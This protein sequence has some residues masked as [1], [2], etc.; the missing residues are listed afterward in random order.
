MKI[1]LTSQKA[2]F[3]I[4]VFRTYDDVIKVF[5]GFMSNMATNSRSSSSETDDLKLEITALRNQI[6]GLMAK[7]GD[8]VKQ[9]KELQEQVI[10]LLNSKSELEKLQTVKDD[11]F[12]QVI[13]DIK[14]PAALIKNLV[15]LLTSYDLQANEQQDVVQD[16]VKTSSK[17]LRL[18]QEVSRVMS[19]ESNRIPLDA[20]EC[21]LNEIVKDVVRLNK[22]A[23]D[24][25]NIKIVIDIDEN[26]PEIVMDPQKISE[27]A[28]N[29]VSNAIKFNTPG[30]MLRVRTYKKDSFIYVEVSDTGIGLTEEDIR[31]AFHKGAK[32]S[33]KPT[34]GENSTGLGLW[35]VKKLV[36]VHNGKV[37]V[38]SVL[39]KGSTFGFMLPIESNINL[40]S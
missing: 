10:T 29:L 27:V 25:K 15:E 1:K 26:L 7:S 16:I 5:W 4:F 3:S 28:E 6:D 2:L 32:L 9:N 33:A 40:E 35:I 36:E 17:I 30:G 34:A 37:W 31:K 38:K 20:F 39:G 23:A 21:Q 13:H 22:T 14:N 11:L 12:A 8:L 18:S 24:A 19:L